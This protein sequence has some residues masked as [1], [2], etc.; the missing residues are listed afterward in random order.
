M[1]DTFSPPSWNS[2][3]PTPPGAVKHYWWRFLEHHLPNVSLIL[4]IASF[5][6]L[7]LYPYMV[8]N[9][10]SGE[11]GVLWKRFDCGTVMEAD[12]LKDEGLH[13]ILPWDVVFRY[14]LRLQSATETYNAI[15]KDGVSLSATINIRFMLDH[16]SVPLVHEAFGPG[17]IDTAVKPEIGSRTREVIARHTAEE[18]YTQRNLIENEIKEATETKMAAMLK[19]MSEERETPRASRDKM[20][21]RCLSKVT[22]VNRHNL[23]K[24]VNLASTLVQGIELPTA[25]V[26]AIN[27]KIEQLYISQEYVYRV[28]RERRESERKRVEAIGI[29]DFQQTVSQGIS[30]SYLRWRGIEATLQLAQS[31][32]TKVVIIGN[33]K[34]GLPIILGNVDSVSTPPPAAEPADGS[35]SKPTAASPAKAAEKTPASGLSTPSEKTPESRSSTPPE[36]KPEPESSSRAE[37]PIFPLTLSDLKAWLAKFNSSADPKSDAA[38][39]AETKPSEIRPSEANPDESKAPESK[40]ADKSK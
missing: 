18:V 4:L 3:Q 35:T 11:V 6:A 38:K 10:D 12:K 23:A 34:D 26:T 40:P 36:T 13:I 16:D 19:G 21:N 14:D 27:R 32:N 33:G 25:V 7:L 28:E 30:D 29:R 2:S 24:S 37:K 20:A 39:P 9:V 5:A 15:S 1:A 17:Y 31:T 8:V 22:E